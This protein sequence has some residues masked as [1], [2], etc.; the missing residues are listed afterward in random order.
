M[1]HRTIRSSDE[2]LIERLNRLLQGAPPSH[3]LYAI[4]K[5]LDNLVGRAIL[6]DI[7]APDGT[8]TYVLPPPMA[9]FFEFSM[10]RL[11]GDIDQRPVPGLWCLHQ[12]VRLHC[13]QARG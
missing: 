2:S 4:L 1:A 8:T 9:G 10:M 13:S 5:L 7:F 6:L 11:R 3:T 12:A